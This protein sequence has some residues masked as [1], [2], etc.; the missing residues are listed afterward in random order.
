MT[1]RPPPE[2]V[3]GVLPP[4]FALPAYGSASLADVLPGVAAAL[5]VPLRRGDL[6]PDPLGLAA[7]LTGVR[8]VAVLLCRLGFD[9]IDINRAVPAAA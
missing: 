8:R 1:S 4:G 3:D 5:D 9:G 6:A 7:A 2:S